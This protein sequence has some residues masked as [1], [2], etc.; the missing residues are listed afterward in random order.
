[1]GLPRTWRE[2]HER[3]PVHVVDPEER[4][5]IDGVL[6]MAGVSARNRAWMAPSCP[7][8]RVA[9]ELYPIGCIA[10]ETDRAA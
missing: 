10:S 3:E 1:M 8:L 7:S 4:L 2:V 6:I 5:A 9:L